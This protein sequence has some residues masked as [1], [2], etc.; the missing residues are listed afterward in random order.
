[1]TD[2]DTLRMRFHIANPV[3]DPDTI[4]AAELDQVLFAIESEWDDVRGLGAS[5]KRLETD[6][7]PWLVPAVVFAAA[8]VLLL[9]AVG[10]PMLFLGGDRELPPVEE[11]TTVATTVATTV[12]A[13]TVPATVPA[14]PSTTT[15]S[16][17]P[18]AASAPPMTWERLPH[19]AI[20]DNASLS[21]IVVGGPG[22]VAGG[23][24]G[25][26]WGEGPSHAAV[27]VSADGQEWERIDLASSGEEFNGITNLA[28]DQNSTLVAFGCG[29]ITQ[30][31]WVSR[32][33]YE[34]ERIA[35]DIFGPGCRVGVQAVVAGGPGF[36]AVGNTVAGNAA[37]WL[38][39][40]GY[41]WTAVEDGDLIAE[42][43]E[44][45]NLFMRD[46]VV[47][48]PGLIA[49]GGSGTA[50]LEL[51]TAPD[52]EGLA[53]WV[54]EDGTDWERLPNLN[55]AWVS[56]AWSDPSGDRVVIFGNDMWTSTDGF[57]WTRHDVGV[58]EAFGWGSLAWDGDRVVAGG[59]D[60]WRVTLS[61]SE[62]RGATWSTIDTDDPTFDGYSPFISDLVK[63]GD[64]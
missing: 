25:D 46:V 32:D 5:P 57:E 23:W 7:R 10:L 6:R 16:A 33:G 26:M 59:G 45:W 38:S 31:L 41:E 18:Q 15:T 56:S 17:A 2:R 20:F 44:K 13:T 52:F 64:T 54:S 14:E 21:S 4:D 48:G 37:V 3:P 43:S 55:D 47:G 50:S 28:A 42:E 9:L 27:F 60:G 40:D 30:P 51:T 58:P 49:I 12:P 1:M 34:W 62:D 8:I 19:Q 29:G 24:E 61:V 53:I 22:L 39:E 11:P 35:T 63:F 36:V